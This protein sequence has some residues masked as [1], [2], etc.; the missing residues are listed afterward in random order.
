MKRI[1]FASFSLFL[2][3][4]GGETFSGATVNVTN[5]HALEGGFHYE[6]WAIVDAAP[7]SLGKFN[8]NAAGD[9][10]DLEGNTIES[11]TANNE[12]T[13]ATDLVITIEPDGDTDQEPASTKMLA[14]VVEGDSATLVAAGAQALNDDFTGAAGD[15]ILATPTD[16]D[17]TNELSGVWFNGLDL[18]ALP[19]GWEYEGWAVI[20]GTPLSTGRFSDATAPDDAAP[21]S[22]AN[23]APPVPGED[24]V[25]NAPAGITF[26][27][28]LATVVISIE[29]SPDDSTAPFQ[30]KPL[31][32]DI[33][34][35]AEPMTGLTFENKAADFSSMTLTLIP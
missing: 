19:A 10:T 7:V 14:G 28:T 26:P 9:I 11:I 24:F 33:P 29:P 31:V 27:A 3:A 17:A 20:D 4:C 1:I 35:D 16:D 12:F 23:D 5:A 22:G 2:A 25:Q 32:H 34:G 8:V 18:P 30:F 21:Y 13:G 6:G 15:Y